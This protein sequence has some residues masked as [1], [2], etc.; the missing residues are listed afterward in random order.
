MPF[1]E[2]TSRILILLLTF[3]V[4]TALKR[5]SWNML[6]SPHVL[7]P[8]D[9]NCYPC[10]SGISIR[11]CVLLNGP[12]WIAIP[13]GIIYVQMNLRIIHFREDVITYHVEIWLSGGGLY[14]MIWLSDHSGHSGYCN[15]GYSGNPLDVVIL[16]IGIL[17]AL[18]I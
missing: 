4:E 15:S 8:H 5:S 2:N 10:L 13:L 9:N 12:K 18:V 16:V 14:K 17:V 11:Q 7:V 6:D 1:T 3:F